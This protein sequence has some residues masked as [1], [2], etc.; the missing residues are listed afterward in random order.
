[1]PI[2]HRNPCYLGAQCDRCL[3]YLAVAYIPKQ[4]ARFVLKFGLLTAIGDVRD[5]VI[6]NIERGD[7]GVA[8]AG[9]DRDFEPGMMFQQPDHSL[10]HRASCPQNGYWDALATP[11][12]LW[13]C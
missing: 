8:R 3:V 1:M 13:M 7:A 4:F 6:E 10:T 5:D 12:G 11:G 9:H 2:D